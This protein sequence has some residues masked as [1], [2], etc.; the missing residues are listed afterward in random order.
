MTH[1][2]CVG[3]RFHHVSID[4]IERSAKSCSKPFLYRAAQLTLKQT[5]WC[6]AEV[7]E[8]EN[9]L[10]ELDKQQ[11]AFTFSGSDWVQKVCCS[12]LVG[13]RKCAAVV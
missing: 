10:L 4:S 12:V 6:P 3:Y 1:C 2:K 11:Q 13:Y 9:N 5:A 7:E 8:V